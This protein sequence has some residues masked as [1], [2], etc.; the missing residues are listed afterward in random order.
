VPKSTAPKKGTK[1]MN[2]TVKQVEETVKA[3]T[4]Q[5]T[6]QAGEVFK[7]INVKAKTAFEKVSVFAKEATEFSKA[8]LEA[9]VDAGKVAASGAQTV[10]QQTVAMGQKNYETTASHLKQVASVKAPAEFLKL[11]SDFARTQFD[12]AVAEM[13]K[14]SEFFLKL[15]GEIVQPIQSRYAVAAEQVKARFAA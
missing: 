15:A 6:A 11:Q 2:D 14:S 3:A 4:A 9:V 5:A 10:A 8:N 1:V 12:S 13:S 7:D